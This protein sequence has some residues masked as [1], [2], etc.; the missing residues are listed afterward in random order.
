M[1]NFNELITGLSEVLLPRLCH[2]CDS[3]LS[4]DERFICAFCAETLPRTGYERTP[5]N[6]VAERFAG[7]IPFDKATG[8][9]QYARESGFAQLTQDFK[10]RHFS[11]LAKELGRMAAN[12]LLYSGFFDGIEALVPVPMFF[13]KRI[14]RGYSQTHCIARGICDVTDIPVIEALSMPSPRKSQ[15]RKPLN[16]R[17]QMPQSAFRLIAPDEIR[18]RRILLVD[19]ICT[20]G[21]TIMAAASALLTANPES[22]SIFTLAATSNV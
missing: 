9:F 3:P 22:L 20:T 10:Y 8:H 19:D 17:R 6:P 18:G 12:E 21:T 11:G 1:V 4:T 15:T 16:S 14:K 5:L 2:L 13:F 7:K